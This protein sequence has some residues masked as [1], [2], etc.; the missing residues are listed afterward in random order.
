MTAVWCFET[1]V[2]T[3]IDSTRSAFVMMASLT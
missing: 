2:C 3:E 1:P